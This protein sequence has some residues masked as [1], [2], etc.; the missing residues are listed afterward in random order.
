[1]APYP[2]YFD[3]NQTAVIDQ[4]HRMIWIQSMNSIRDGLYNSVSI[5]FAIVSYGR[6][7]GEL[8]SV[9]DV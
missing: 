2:V 8:R 3:Q 1:M 5:H 6:T 4:V 9:S 7:Y